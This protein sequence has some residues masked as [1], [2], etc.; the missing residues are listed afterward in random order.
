MEGA[1]EAARRVA[2]HVRAAASRRITLAL[3]L[4]ILQSGVFNLF[5]EGGVGPGHEKVLR[6]AWGVFRGG[7]AARAGGWPHL[8]SRLSLHC[9]MPLSPLLNALTMETSWRYFE[10]STGGG[11]CEGGGANERVGARDQ[12]C[13]R[14]GSAAPPQPLSAGTCPPTLKQAVQ[15]G[16][17][18]DGVG[19]DVGLA[20]APQRAARRDGPAA[21]LE[22]AGGTPGRTPRALVQQR[23][24]TPS[25]CIGAERGERERTCA[26]G[27]RRVRAPQPRAATPPPQRRQLAPPP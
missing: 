22:S 24:G 2:P 6:G 12:P 1:R 17:H 14:A 26:F 5:H 8:A 10:S 13:A 18:K 19:G 9:C 23:N 11:A 16:R 27:P 15:V 3:T 7:R 25:P 21:A 4:F 20:L